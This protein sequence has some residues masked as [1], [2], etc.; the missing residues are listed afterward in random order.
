MYWVLTL[1]YI[2]ISRFLKRTQGVDHCSFRK[3]SSSFKRPTFVPGFHQKCTFACTERGFPNLKQVAVDHFRCRHYPILCIS[4]IDA[5]GI[6]FNLLNF[7]RFY[8]IR[9]NILT[10]TEL[11]PS[12]P[13][14]VD[15]IIW[16]DMLSYGQL[17]S[18]FY[19]KVTDV[20]LLFKAAYDWPVL[21]GI[22]TIYH[23]KIISY[24]LFSDIIFW[25]PL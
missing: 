25:F 4:E 11:F 20:Y 24:V 10:I 13:F 18:H 22:I 9:S 15:S 14:L 16:F 12:M 5:L 21:G 7:K 19:L 2:Y 23:D 6:S 8:N 3:S 17:F 1:R